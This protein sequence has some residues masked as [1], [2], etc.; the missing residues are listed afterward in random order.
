[1]PIKYQEVLSLRYFGEKSLK[2]ICEILGKSEGT[3]KSLLHR[4]IEKLKKDH[5]AL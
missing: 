5:I 3:V 2:E 4:G 1:L